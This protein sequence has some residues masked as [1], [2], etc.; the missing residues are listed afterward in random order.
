MLNLHNLPPPG[1]EALAHSALVSQHIRAQIAA[2]QGPI[3]FVRF[4][5]LAL[6]A[7]GLGYY[8]A[9][10]K[11][12]GSTGDFVTAP[13]ISPLYS[14]C[15]A[16]QCQQVLEAMGVGDILEVGAGSG[17]M[18]SD[19]LLE[20][21]S[22]QT[23]PA[24][25]YILEISADLRERQ[26]SLLSLQC[27]HLMNRIQWLTS[28]PASFKGVVL[29]NELLDAM[30]VHRIV[31]TDNGAVES[32]VDAIDNE[33]VWREGG[34]S[35]QGVADRIE[36]LLAEFGATH[37][38]PGYTTE[39]NLAAE[40]W[41]ESLAAVMQQGLLL[42]IDYG[43]PRHEYYHADRVGGTIMCH[44][45][46]YAHDNPFI[47]A[48]I[49]DITAHIDFT[50]MAQSGSDAGLDV[51]GYTTQAYFLLALGLDQMVAYSDPTDI[52]H[53]LVLTQQ[54]KKL[55]SP[56]EMGELFKVLALSRGLE[57]PLRGFTLIDHRMRL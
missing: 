3:P 50:A 43:F 29:A 14:R 34:I 56:S 22:L 28:L 4:M 32:Y 9:G 13:E 49:T 21:E 10:A 33:F 36:V 1:D 57:I 2:H 53:H 18:A 20:L 51:S 24:H 25:Y 55:T 44:Y 5:D 39:I 8:S 40:A 35:T 17:V 11:K 16:R 48:G 30:P 45:R 54:V 15:I 7:P 12:I 46:H 23:L 42:I 6:H 37:F 41:I 19:I 27:A 52:R 26:E 31:F 38:Q 47:F